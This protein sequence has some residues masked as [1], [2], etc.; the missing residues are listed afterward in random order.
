MPRRPRHMV[1][2]LADDTLMQTRTQ[3]GAAEVRI[4]TENLYKFHANSWIFW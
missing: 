3:S 2:C 1:D 4:L